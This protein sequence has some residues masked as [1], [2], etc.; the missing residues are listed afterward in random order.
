MEKNARSQKTGWIMILWR[1]IEKYLPIKGAHVI[2]SDGTFF[3][4][5]CWDF[6]N[7]VDCPYS[8]DMYCDSLC[9]MDAR[10][11]YWAYL[12]SIHDPSDE[13]D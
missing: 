12:S 4:I 1:D 3:N 11:R 13:R 6:D 9:L 5:I 2:V 10:I 7:Q 8:S